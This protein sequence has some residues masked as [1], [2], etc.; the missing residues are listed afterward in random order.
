M[1]GKHFKSITSLFTVVAIACGLLLVSGVELCRAQSI[2][3][4]ISEGLGYAQDFFGPLFPSDS[5]YNSFR[6]EMG[7]GAGFGTAS[8]IRL[9]PENGNDLALDLRKSPLDDM[10]FRYEMCGAFR[11]WRLGA[12]VSYTHLESG[13]EDQANLFYRFSPLKLGADI[14]IVRRPWL[15]LGASG[16]FYFTAPFLKGLT[17]G[18]EID[19]RGT[20]PITAG[21]YLRY[22]PPDILGFPLHFEARAELPVTKDTRVESYSS[23][24]VFRPQIYRF[25]AAIKFGFERQYTTIIAT[26]EYYDD[27]IGVGAPALQSFKL[28]TEWNFYGFLASVYF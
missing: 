27:T 11:L 26:P 9:T 22:I 14:D 4:M 6:S 8:V 16:D 19:L 18:F 15:S 5:L 25:D 17:R 21:A 3:G 28:Q 7:V 2:D 24:L 23:W 12:R 13:K 10:P 1:I 20:R